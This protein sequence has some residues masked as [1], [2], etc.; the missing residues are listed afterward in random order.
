MRSMER[1]TKLVD[2]IFLG[3]TD[4]SEEFIVGTP[5]GCAECR[6][7]ARRL[8]VDAADLVFCN[9]ICGTPRRLVPDDDPRD[10]M[11]VL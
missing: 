7:V 11:Y 5:A 10:W 8:R 4:G 6:T 1:K 9:S 2:G 3:I